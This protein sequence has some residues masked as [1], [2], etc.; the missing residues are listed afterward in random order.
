MLLFISPA[1]PYM[2]AGV[3]ILHRH[4]ELLT[5]NHIPAAIVYA[6]PTVRVPDVP[7]VP[8]R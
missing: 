3:R 5:K 7:Q 2:S 1:P 6:D 8:V 4:V